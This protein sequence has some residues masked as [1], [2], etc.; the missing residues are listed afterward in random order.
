MPAAAGRDVLGGKR[1]D[2]LLKGL[3]RVGELENHAGTLY[4]GPGTSWT[5]EYVQKSWRLRR[6]RPAQPMAS[7]LV[8][9]SVAL[10]REMR[11]AVHAHRSFHRR[12]RH[13][14]NARV[15]RGKPSLYSRPADTAAGSD[16]AGRHIVVDRGRRRRQCAAALAPGDKLQLFAQA[17]YTDDSR[18]DVTNTALW[19]S[20]NPIVAT[21]SSGGV[22][23]GAAEGSLDVNATYQDALRLATCRR[24]EARVPRHLSPPSLSFSAFG[25]SATVQV[26]MS[27]STCRWTAKSDAS[28]LPFSTNPNKSGNGAFSYTVPGNSTTQ[29][30]TG[31]IVSLGR[32]RPERLAHGA[33]GAAARVQLRGDARP[34]HVPGRGGSG[35]TLNW[36]HDAG[37]LAR[38]TVHP[39]TAH[40]WALRLTGPASGTGNRAPDLYRP[41]EPLLLRRISTTDRSPRTERAEPAGRTHSNGIVRK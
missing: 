27:D 13:V 16:D 4:A 33:A 21:V 41:V 6:G 23:T 39:M 18:V 30:R 1:C 25:A 20:S 10:Q 19:Q 31:N 3:L 28:W 35:R 37:Q 14:R 24:P 29:A 15:R 38:W 2:F 34:H 32:R 36:S 9:I 5:S 22:L 26:T 17:V 8:I 12:C 11:M 40:P 7:S